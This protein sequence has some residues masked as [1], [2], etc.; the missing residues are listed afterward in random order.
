MRAYDFD[1]RISAEAWLD[2]YRGAAKVVVATTHEGLRVQFHAKH[3]QPY[4]TRDG[5]RGTFRLV[6]DD[7]NN[8][9]RLEQLSSPAGG[10]V[11]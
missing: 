1:L 3:L 11:A 2:Y 9:V 5:V 7:R 10:W 6:V 4:L 8:F